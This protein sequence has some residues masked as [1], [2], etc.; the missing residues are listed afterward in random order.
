V[1]KILT[2]DALFEYIIA[3]YVNASADNKARY[4]KGEKIVVGMLGYPNVG[5]SSTINVLAGSKKVVTSATPGKTKHFQ[6]INVGD[7]ITLC[8]CPGLVFPTFLSSRAELVC[9]GIMPIDQIKDWKNIWAPVQLL[10]EKVSRAQIQQT[11]SLIFPTYKEMSADD[12]LNSYARMRSFYKDHGRPDEAHAARIILKDFCKGKLLY[13]H[14][15]PNISFEQRRAFYRSFHVGGEVLIHESLFM[16][17]EELKRAREAQLA[18]SVDGLAGVKEEETVGI[19]GMRQLPVATQRKAAKAAKKAAAKKAAVAES[20]EDVESDEESEDDSDD[21]DDETE[22]GLALTGHRARSTV[23]QLVLEAQMR[24][25]LSELVQPTS[26][27]K[28]AAKLLAQGFNPDGTPLSKK[29][30]QRMGQR[31]KKKTGKAFKLRKTTVP[32]EE[33]V[34]PHTNTLRAH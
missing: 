26:H 21:D 15:P 20:K 2:R 18:A 22:A 9:N 28:D 8:D 31:N 14:P 4:E 13:C 11:Y 29:Q 1:H 7:Q 25:D 6:T 3:K 12:L 32:M 30:L 5:K 34:S 17:P 19:V 16:A 27:N 24:D 33:V 10:C 23:N